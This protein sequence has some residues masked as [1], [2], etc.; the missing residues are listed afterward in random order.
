MGFLNDSLTYIMAFIRNALFIF[1]LILATRL[2]MKI[3]KYVMNLNNRYKRIN[4]LKEG[5]VT[6]EDIYEL[7]PREFESWCKDFLDKEGY[8]RIVVSPKGPDGGKD[9]ECK[10]GT[11]TYYVECKRYWQNSSARFKV[12]AAIC[13]KLLGAMAANNVQNGIIMT[14]GI[15]TKDALAFLRSLPEPYKLEAYDG[16]DLIREYSLRNIYTPASTN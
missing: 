6:L 14:T 11:I 4:R 10:K 16:D 15:I 1:F 13:K 8:T 5:I 7:T 9:I 12:D 2:S 3:F